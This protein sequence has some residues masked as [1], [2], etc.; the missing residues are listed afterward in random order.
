LADEKMDSTIVRGVFEHAVMLDS[1]H[2]KTKY[3]NL[4]TILRSERFRAART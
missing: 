3:Q 2:A 1:A 4:I